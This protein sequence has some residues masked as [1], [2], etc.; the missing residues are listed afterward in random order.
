M[1][2]AILEVRNLH[3]HYPGVNAVNGIDF[4]VRPGICFGLLRTKRGG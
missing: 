1:T 3:K 2:Q 4:A